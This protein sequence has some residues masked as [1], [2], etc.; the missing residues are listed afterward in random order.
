MA[1][2]PQTYSRATQDAVAL[3]GLHIA[4]ARRQRRFTAADLAQRAGISLTTL[5][6]AERGVPTVAV[7][8]V[9]ELAT[10]LG[11]RLF[12]AE[13]GNLRDLVDRQADRLALLPAH[14]HVG[15]Q[16]A[17]DDDF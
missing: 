12:G 14:V 4:T 6:N 1:R 10:L 9:F 16:N 17:A 8:I 2:K 15:P 3:L 13:P 11:I 7:G 5:R